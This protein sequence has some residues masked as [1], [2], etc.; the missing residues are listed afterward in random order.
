MDLQDFLSKKL[1]AAINNL[2]T[3]F[4]DFSLEDQ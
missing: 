2:A 1:I 3:G 4:I